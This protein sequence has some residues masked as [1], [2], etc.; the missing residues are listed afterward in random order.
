MRMGTTPQIATVAFAQWLLLA[1]FAA[2]AENALVL[3]VSP[4][5]NAAWSGQLTKPNAGKTDGPLAS[6]AG[7]RDAIHKLKTQGA[8][9]KPIRV[10]VADGLYSLTEPLVFTPEDSGTDAAPVTY[11]AARGARPVFSGGRVLAGGERGTRALWQTQVAV[12]RYG[13][14][15]FAQLLGDRRRAPRARPPHQLYLYIAG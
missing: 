12:G 6:L 2:R 4:A 9:T 10:L 14:S 7:A 5:G 11:E 15:D 8:L 3:H 1:S 13:R